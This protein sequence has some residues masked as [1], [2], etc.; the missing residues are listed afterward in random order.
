MTTKDKIRKRFDLLAEKRQYW[1]NRNKYH[2]NKQEK[3]FNLLNRF[4]AFR[5]FVVLEKT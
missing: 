1:R 5:L 4:L 2:Y 3:L